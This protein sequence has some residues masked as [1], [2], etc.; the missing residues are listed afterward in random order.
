MIGWVAVATALAVDPGPEEV[1]DEPEAEAVSEPG[2]ASEP[3]PDPVWVARTDGPLRQLDRVVRQAR[4]R[5]ATVVPVSV[6]AR[7]LVFDEDQPLDP[8]WQRRVE[9]RLGSPLEQRLSCS[10]ARYP[11]GRG[12]VV[13]ELQAD[14]QLDRRVRDVTAPLTMSVLTQPLDGRPASLCVSKLQVQPQ[15]LRADL[16]ATGVVVQGLYE[17]GGCV[18]QR[19]RPAARGW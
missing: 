16:E 6:G 19:T 17:V 13:A 11:M 7:C 4:R 5:G 2:P 1:A 10:I 9:R 18:A 14:P 3:E 8:D 15:A 12:W